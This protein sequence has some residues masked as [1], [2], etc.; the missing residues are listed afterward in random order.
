MDIDQRHHPRWPDLSPRLKGGNAVES[1]VESTLLSEM[2][3]D[4]KCV[5]DVRRII[6]SPTSFQN[7]TYQRLYEIV[8]IIFDQF[9]TCD[10]VMLGEY[11][12][13]REFK[14]EL[15]SLAQFISQEYSGQ[16]S[17]EHAKVVE[18]QAVHRKLKDLVREMHGELKI[19]SDP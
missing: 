14:D 8:L 18:Q 16:H 13:I 10:A 12:K 5:P 4:P 6:S 15:D 19:T 7:K 2:V 9:G 17:I 3:N 1:S 11:L